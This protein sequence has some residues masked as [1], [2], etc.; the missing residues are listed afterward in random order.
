MKNFIKYIIAMMV[1]PLLLSSCDD[2]LDVNKH[3]NK[4]TDPT[5]STLATSAIIKT[6][7]LHTSF[8]L[9]ANRY[10]QHISSVGS[11]QTDQY[12]KNTMS[13]TWYSLY[14]GVLADLD[15]LKK[16][17]E[18]ENAYHFLGI[19]EIMTA[20]NIG[21]ATDMWGA[22]PYSEA[23]Q[24]NE[25]YLPKFDTQTEIYTEVFR[26]LD[27]A[28]N[29]LQR[30][31]GTFDFNTISGSFDLLYSGDASAWLKL[32]YAYKARFLNHWSKTSSYDPA[33]IRTAVQN[34]FTSYDDDAN[35]YYSE[36]NH[37]PYYNIVLS[38][39]TGNLSV[40]FSDYLIQMLNG[41][42]RGNGIDPRLAIIA[43]TTGANGVYQ[44][45]IPGTTSDP[46]RQE[47]A[48]TEN[49]FH[50]GMLAPIELMTYAELQFILAEVE[51]NS[52]NPG[53]AYTAWENG[54]RANMAKLGVDALDI[55]D[56]L[57][58]LGVDASNI[59]IADVMNEKYIAT[60]LNYDAW[61]DLRRYDYGDGNTTYPGFSQPVD[62]DPELGGAWVRRVMYPLTEENRNG[63]NVDEAKGSNYSMAKPLTWDK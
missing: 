16:L 18:T 7:D 53:A 43:D 54:V 59:T 19:A 31:D 40:T 44:G 55:D 25:N 28:I 26:L 46:N 32:A 35:F 60:F 12:Y 33:A 61:T 36:Q 50:F 39:N 9:G 24:G 51:V 62:P 41:N 29:N 63:T 37:S 17:A 56:Y 8:S 21:A 23:L 45:H 6:A 42:I 57:A 48:F 2:F 20:A 30:T 38:N 49:C 15:E 10:S 13:G 47:L 27:D 52:G 58:N 34:S 5:L 4:Q 11:S 14:T 1:I 22:M 3:P